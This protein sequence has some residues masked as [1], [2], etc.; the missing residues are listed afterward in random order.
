MVMSFLKV[1]LVR[2]LGPVADGWE[3]PLGVSPHC[4]ADAGRRPDD[5]RPRW[6]GPADTTPVSAGP[7]ALPDAAGIHRQWG[8]TAYAALA[9]AGSG[10]GAGATVAGPVTRSGPERNRAPQTTAPVAK[11]AAATQNPVV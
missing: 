4:L 6:P 5:D 7:A 3:L 10:T 8:D 11:M 1:L 2:L 9:V